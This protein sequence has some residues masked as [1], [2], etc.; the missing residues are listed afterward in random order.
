M[1]L[2]YLS[3]KDSDLSCCPHSKYVWHMNVCGGMYLLSVPHH[4]CIP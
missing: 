2:P 1:L 3:A 4:H